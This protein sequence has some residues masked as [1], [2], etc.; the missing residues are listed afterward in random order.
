[1]LNPEG[2]AEVAAIAGG[3]QTTQVSDAGVLTA[4][5]VVIVQQRVTDFNTVSAAQAKTAGATLVDIH[6]LFAGVATSGLSIGGYTGTNGFLGGFFSLDGIHPTNTGYAVVA[7]T[8]IDAM[9]AGFSAK[10]PEVNVATV[11]AADPLWPPNLGATVGAA[12]RLPVGAGME[13]LRR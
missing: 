4:A 7:N 10:I 2:L 5:E 12:A 11:A 1:L 13:L 8:F 6:A 9:N 3:T